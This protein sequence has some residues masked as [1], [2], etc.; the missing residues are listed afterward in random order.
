LPP[1][2]RSMLA[3]RAVLLIQSVRYPYAHPL[4]LLF[5]QAQSSQITENFSPVGRRFASKAVPLSPCPIIPSSPLESA[6]RSLPFY[7]PI[8]HPKSFRCNTSISVDSKQLKVPLESTLMKKRGRGGQLSLTRSVNQNPNNGFF[9]RATIGSRP[10]SP[11]LVGAS[12]HVPPIT[13]R[14]VPNRTDGAT[15]PHVYSRCA[16]LPI[17]RS[18]DR[19]FLPPW[20][21]S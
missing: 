18:G 17:L 10:T 5:S 15:P 20:R 7:T 14:P 9:L 13:S 21:L 16:I 6:L 4:N 3:R 11:D 2:L 19:P 8:S 1:V 12:N